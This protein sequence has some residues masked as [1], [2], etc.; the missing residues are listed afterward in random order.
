[1]GRPRANDRKVVEDILYVLRAGC[2]KDLP[3]EFGLP[4]TAWRR[5]KRWEEHGT[6]ERLWLTLLARLDEAQKLDWGKAF[7]DA[8]FIP[9]KKGECRSA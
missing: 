2:W 9:A 8:S 5:L 4:V 3:S 6:W 1:M 7:L